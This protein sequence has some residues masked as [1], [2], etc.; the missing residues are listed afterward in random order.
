MPTELVIEVKP[1]VTG[2]AGQAQLRARDW[3]ELESGNLRIIPARGDVHYDSENGT[4]K[5]E[6]TLAVLRTPPQP[7]IIIPP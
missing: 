7:Q 1:G 4:F 3:I 5:I 6:I 2:Q